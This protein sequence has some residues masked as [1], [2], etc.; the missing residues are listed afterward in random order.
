MFPDLSLSPSPWVWRLEAV[1]CVAKD[2][3]AEIWE[4]TESLTQRPM[5]TKPSRQET[6]CSLRVGGLKVVTL[7]RKI[8]TQTRKHTFILLYTGTF[9]KPLSSRIVSHCGEFP[10]SLSFCEIDVQ[11]DISLICVFSTELESVRG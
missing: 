4:E 6:C 7:R 3:P 9:S 1:S 10:Y 5:E 8:C 2:A 11:M